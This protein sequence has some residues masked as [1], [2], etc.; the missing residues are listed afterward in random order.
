MHGEEEEGEGGDD[1]VKDMDVMYVYT[2]VS[3]NGF[4]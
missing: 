1:F 3:I 2:E 4:S